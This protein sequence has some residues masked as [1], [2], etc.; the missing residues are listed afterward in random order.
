VTEL[1]GAAERRDPTGHGLH[2]IL[3][4]LFCALG[5][6]A[7]STLE[8][9]SALLILYAIARLPNTWRIYPT[10]VTTW[11]WLGLT[12]WSAWTFATVLWSADRTEGAVQCGG[13]RMFLVIP[14]LWPVIRHRRGLAMCLVAGMCF[15]ALGVALSSFGLIRHGADGLNRYVGFGSH[16]GHVTLWLSI[17]AITAI[18]LVRGAGPI[19]RWFLIAAAGAL[20]VAA[21]TAGGRGSLLGLVAGGGVILIVVLMSGLLSARQWLAAGAVLIV[22]GATTAF[23]RG[24]DLKRAVDRIERQ[25]N[26]SEQKGDPRSSTAYRLYWWQ[27]SLEQWRESPIIG[28]GIGS[29][30]PWATS[31]SETISLADR[32]DTTTDDLILAHPHSVYLQTIGETG[33]I[34]GI[35]MLIVGA[36]LVAGSV[37]ASRR[38]PV[39]L[40]GIASLA[41]WSISSGFEG[42]HISPRGTAAFAVAA[43][44]AILPGLIGDSADRRRRAS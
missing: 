2:L 44:F 37:A 26:R 23:L 40:A 28:T 16:T 34:G 25:L 19:A 17:A 3:A 12:A 31:R 22:I 43:S 35:L 41:V 32:L 30:R 1:V 29:W 42:N 36:S 38:D 10:L 9:S 20:I 7:T 11:S 21:T 33:A 39:A 14:A 5:G 15:Q 18:A 6:V 13:F 27:L 24:D 8:I 4:G